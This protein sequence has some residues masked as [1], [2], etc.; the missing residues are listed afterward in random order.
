MLLKLITKDSAHSPCRP[1][2]L[3]LHPSGVNGQGGGAGVKQSK[4]K[5][6]E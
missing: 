5:G 6:I 1:P 2:T 3:T 4:N